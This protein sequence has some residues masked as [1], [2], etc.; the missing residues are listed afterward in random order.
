M[1]E[2]GYD[3]P[4]HV[5]TVSVLEEF[6][7]YVNPG[8]SVMSSPI[9]PTPVYEFNRSLTNK[10][11][12]KMSGEGLKQGAHLMESSPKF[13][14]KTNLMELMKRRDEVNHKWFQLR[15]KNG[16]TSIN[17]RHALEREAK[18]LT[19]QIKKLIP[20]KITDNASKYV[21]GLPADQ[22]RKSRAGSAS[23][24]L[25][26]KGAGKMKLT[27]L[28]RLNISGLAFHRNLIKGFKVL[29]DGVK[30]VGT[31][32]NY[33]LAGYEILN[34]F[35][36]GGNPLRTAFKEG[37]AIYAG[38]VLSAAAGG[39]LAGLG[40]IAIGTI[41]GDAALGAA[42]LVCYPVIG[43][44]VLVIAGA[45]IAGYVSY[46]TKDVAERVWDG[47]ESGY[48]KD[49]VYEYAEWIYNEFKSLGSQIAES[50]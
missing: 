21:H 14:A 47:V 18:E 1:Q 46:Q 19:S 43:W 24:K 20:K 33:T 12:I 4:T 31:Y 17:D 42:I 38:T 16:L 5:A 48:V 6:Q 3:I 50:F 29:G 27:H 8:K 30:K 7:G 34:S 49:Q 2:D 15:G 36:N 37:S 40:G 28:E 25:A 10:S 13:I 22:A 35:L 45:A 39:T 41:A 9:F 44:V 11:L 23:L 26:K 32:T